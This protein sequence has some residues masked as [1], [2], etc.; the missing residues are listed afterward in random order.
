M[1]SV[2][3]FSLQNDTSIVIVCV[4][5]CVCHCDIIIS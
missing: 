4:C 1:L 3:K 2:H 5:V